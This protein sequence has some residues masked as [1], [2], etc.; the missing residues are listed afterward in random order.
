MV[1]RQ[2]TGFMLNFRGKQKHKSDIDILEFL[3]KIT[4]IAQKFEIKIY[5][6]KSF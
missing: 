5:Q 2:K 3:L 4:L 6:W 1:L